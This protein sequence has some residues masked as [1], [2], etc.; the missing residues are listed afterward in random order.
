MGDG[1]DM[2]YFIHYVGFNCF[3][4]KLFNMF[5]LAEFFVATKKIPKHYY[6]LSHPQQLHIKLQTKTL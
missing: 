3:L 2:R 6:P 4:K 5:L 1:Y